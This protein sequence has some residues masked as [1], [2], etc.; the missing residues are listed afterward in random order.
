MTIVLLI[1]VAAV[2]LVAGGAI[3]IRSLI[4]AAEREFFP[5]RYEKSP[6]VVRRCAGA[7]LRFALAGVKR[8]RLFGH[9]LFVR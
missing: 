2:S 5:E 7:C 9:A 8:V 3:T 6:G 1:L 4:R